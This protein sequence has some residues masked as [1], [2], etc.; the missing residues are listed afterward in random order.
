MRNTEKIKEL[1]KIKDQQGISCT[2]SFRKKAIKVLWYN[3]ILKFERLKNYNDIITIKDLS[4]SYCST[5][6][7]SNNW[8]DRIKIWFS[9]YWKFLQMDTY[10]KK[11]LGVLK[12]SV[13]SSYN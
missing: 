2:R 5:N 9:I 13:R 10:I 8:I 11:T 12:W 1:M 4:Y 7:I 3:Q 6:S